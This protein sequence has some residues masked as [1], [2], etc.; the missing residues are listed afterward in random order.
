MTSLGLLLLAICIV[1][2]A[3]KSLFNK[4]FALAYPGAKSSATPVFSI[5]TG[6]G[7]AIATFIYN[8][9]CGNTFTASSTTWIMGLVNGMVL[10]GFN[11][12]VINASL[13]GPYAFQ[14]L[15]STSGNIIL[16]LLFTA[17]WCGDVLTGRQW[18]GIVIMLLSFVIFNLK[19]LKLDGAKKS[20]FFWVALLF[21][22]NGIYGIM[23]DA[24]QRAMAQ[25][26]RNEMI[27]ITFLTCAVISVV[28]LLI[29]NKGDPVS[30]FRMGKK[31][32]IYSV[33]TSAIYALATN[34]MV[35]AITLM[36]AAILY[37]ALNGGVL[38][39]SVLLGITL[40]HEKFNICKGLGLALAVA[41]LILLGI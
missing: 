21:T 2:F 31:P 12:S 39:L 6:L 22:T 20:Y 29:V 13:T 10:F 24:Q 40:F 28:Y 23:L 41:A 35:V 14:S 25:T 16:P 33:S 9:C 15:M 3:T 5:I 1:C 34:L 38:V 11:L 8:I 30:P 19:D 26:Q 7:C 4:V 37:T 32:W 27:I 18:V 17:L 36:P